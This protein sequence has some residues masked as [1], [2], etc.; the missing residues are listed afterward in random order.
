MSAECVHHWL[1]PT[2]EPGPAG[3]LMSGHCRNCGIT[4][5]YKRS[6]EPLGGPKGRF[7]RALG[8]RGRGAQERGAA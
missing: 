7:N 3:S 4:R 8:V 1:L 6:P 2:P 5:V